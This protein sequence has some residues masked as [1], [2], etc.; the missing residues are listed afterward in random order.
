MKRLIIIIIFVVIAISAPSLMKLQERKDKTKLLLNTVP[1]NTTITIN[2]INGKV[3][4][5]YVD[6]GDYD[7][8]VSKSGFETINDKITVG[9]NTKTKTYILTPVSESAKKWAKD[10]QDKYREAEGEVGRETQ[11]SGKDFEKNNP[12]TKYLP[13]RLPDYSINYQVADSDQNKII[14]T[15]DARDSNSR[16]LAIAQIKSWGMKP[17]DYEISFDNFSNPLILDKGPQL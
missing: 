11:E 6:P 16:Q 15:I 13:F 17:G 2:K 14:I 7:I 12:I 3:G 9:S 10:N 8:S 1:D 5:N 4:S